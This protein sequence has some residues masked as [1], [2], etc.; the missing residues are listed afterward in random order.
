MDTEST[1]LPPT[2][3]RSKLNNTLL[4]NETSSTFSCSIRN[5]SS[6]SD[7]NS[8][9]L[10]SL[11]I[12]NETV[13]SPLSTNLADIITCIAE[14]LTLDDIRALVCTNKDWS[15]S[16]NLLRYVHTLKFSDL[17]LNN[18][19]TN[20]N[21]NNKENEKYPI[22]IHHPCELPEPEQMIRLS[23]LDLTGYINTGSPHRPIRTS[24]IQSG[25][26]LSESNT[27]R[28]S[29][30]TS[31][32]TSLTSTP[33]NRASSIISPK[34]P[35]ILTTTTN[36]L[37]LTSSKLLCDSPNSQ[38]SNT[39][40]P[41]SITLS[42]ENNYTDSSINTRSSSLVSSDSYSQ[43]AQSWLAKFLS[44]QYCCLRLTVLKLS[45][46]VPRYIQEY[47][48]SQC[49]NIRSLSLR[50]CEMTD[51]SLIMK[52][53]ISKELKAIDLNS[54]WRITDEGIQHIQQTCPNM[55]K[56]SIYIS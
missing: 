47:F 45:N 24:S 56:V 4:V 16:T 8:S 39:I 29:V 36:T 43:S 25:K 48:L 11:N 35:N 31:T 30:V 3:S 13:S 27:A 42:T 9:S 28:T 23:R 40:L 22:S 51:D 41:R 33:N 52:L 1:Y 34:E 15:Q 17:H 20:N 12:S 32:S 44:N 55:E 53:P 21:I 6:S 2:L 50:L 26:H 14:M 37:T 5:P 49:K 54:C 19:N 7:I 18:N 10:F 46:T 38:N